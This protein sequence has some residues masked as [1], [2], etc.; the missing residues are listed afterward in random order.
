MQLLATQCHSNRL[1]PAHWS[2]WINQSISTTISK[3]LR[4]WLAM[5]SQRNC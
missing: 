1:K 5:K 2:H 3:K 4:W